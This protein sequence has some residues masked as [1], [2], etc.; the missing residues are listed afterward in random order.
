[1]KGIEVMMNRLLPIKLAKDAKI[2]AALVTPAAKAITVRFTV[3]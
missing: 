3:K 1:L 2:V